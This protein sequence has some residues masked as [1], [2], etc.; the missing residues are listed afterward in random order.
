[1]SIDVKLGG[2]AAKILGKKISSTEGVPRFLLKTP[3]LTAS[4]F[5]SFRSKRRYHQI[6]GISGLKNLIDID[7]HMNERQLY[8]SLHIAG[9][10]RLE[11]SL[12]QK[13]VKNKL[14]KEIVFLDFVE[15]MQYLLAGLDIYLSTSFHEGSSHAIM[16]AMAAGK[17][18][19]AFDLSSMPELVEDNKTGYLIPY[20]DTQHIY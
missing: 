13:C 1:V 5:I 9:S 20:P 16:E 7:K 19:I 8:F 4:C 15:N 6:P 11:T 17:P 12:K 10:G 14:E 18:F 3:F 2:L